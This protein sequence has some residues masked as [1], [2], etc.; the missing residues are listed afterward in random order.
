MTPVG[1]TDALRTAGTSGPADSVRSVTAE[2]IAAGVGFL[3]YIHRLHLAFDGDG[4][5]T[6]VVKLPTDTEYRQI[7]ELTGAYQREVAF[8]SEVLPSAPLNAPR[9][10]VAES[11]EGS[12]DF[13]L[14]LDDLAHLD[15]ADHVAGL[16]LRR[17]G[18][19]IDELA[20]FH[21][22][23]WGD[24]RQAALPAVFPAIDGEA[25]VG[26][27]A[28]GIA[29]G[30]AVH[31]AHG[32]I[33]PPAGLAEFVAGYT[34]LLPA[35]ASEL[36]APA[37][38]VNGDLRVDNLFFDADDNPSTVD[39]QLVMRGSGMIDVAYLVGQGVATDVRRGHERELVERYVAGLRAA[40]ID[41]YGFEQAWRQFRI[42]VAL[43]VT[44]PL[45]A[46]MSW[47]NLNDRAHELVLTLAERSFAVID[48][49]D[50]LAVLEG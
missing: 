44:F 41:G 37:T 36:A 35:L 26:L 16:S 49:V 1:R 48:D 39:F 4:P 17:A 2:Q 13:V 3:S 10:H 19:V 21:A 47:E 7:A 5:A 14:V 9:A 30:W 24:E 45:T 38:L 11:A 31:E 23:G 12:T 32:R 6:L 42:A 40:G 46:M 33:D 8:Y 28:M 15:G 22:W 50:A 43:Q 20:R 27:Y 29:A 34:E 25:T 18:R